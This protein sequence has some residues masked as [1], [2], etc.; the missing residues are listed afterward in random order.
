MARFLRSYS[1]VRWTAA[2]A[3]LGLCLAVALGCGVK[4]QSPDA[5]GPRTSSPAQI[6]AATPALE[7]IRA[8][9][10]GRAG[11]LAEAVLDADAHNAYAAAARAMARFQHSMHHLGQ[12]TIAVLDL[13]DKRGFDHARMRAAL[14]QTVT[15]YIAID[16][17]LAVAA[18]DAAFE[19]ELC[20]ACW[21]RDWNHSGEIDEGDRRLLQIEID[22]DGNPIP[23][24]DPR[25]TPT[26]RF[27]LGDLYWARAMV[28]FQR[29]ALELILAYQWTEIDKLLTMTMSGSMPVITIH[30]D[31]P[32]RIATAR[33]LILAGVDHAARSREAYLA[34]TDDDREWVPNPRQQNHPLPLPV[35]EA[36]YEVWAGVL[37]DVGRLVA[38]EEALSVSELAQLGDHQWDN[39]PRGYIHI[40]KMLA[41]PKDIVFDLP[42]LAREAQTANGDDTAMVERVLA[43]VLGEYYL[44]EM[45][46]SPLVARLARMKREMDRG[47][48]TLERKLRYLLWLN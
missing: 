28:S 31:D 35:D 8:A 34:E 22:A 16:A 38:G 10:F 9:E 17:D 14:E 39:P 36:L 3:A 24:G 44:M 46:P 48:D 4:T 40:G 11:A 23:K 5:P 7:A 45:T 32:A 27:D 2:R 6:E 20:M 25:R 18:G 26:F 37:G 19:F 1:I 21:E 13:T 33:E 42:A 12:E 15:A 41:E 30:L 43:S 47:E 29:A